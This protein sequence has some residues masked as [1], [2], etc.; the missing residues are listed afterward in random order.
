MVKLG[1][2]KLD[3][4]KAMNSL[5]DQRRILF[6]KELIPDHTKGLFDLG[7]MQKALHDWSTDI[8]KERNCPHCGITVRGPNEWFR[9]H[10]KTH[11]IKAEYQEKIKDGDTFKTDSKVDFV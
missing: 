4:Q 9:H 7:N 2:R 1:I 11:Y 3:H 6:E 8:I 10:I 5:L